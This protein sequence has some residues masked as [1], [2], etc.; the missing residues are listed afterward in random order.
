MAKFTFTNKD[1]LQLPDQA[2]VHDTLDA[3]GLHGKVVGL[4]V[5]IDGLTHGFPNDLDMLL[6]GPDGQHNL[7]FMSD[8]GGSVLSSG[9][10]FSFG[11]DGATHMTTLAEGTFLPTDNGSQEDASAWG[12]AIPVVNHPSSATFASAFGGIDGN[13]E[14]SL[15]S[16]DD[17]F[18]D[19]GL[20]HHWKVTVETD[21][22]SADLAGTD[23][24]DIIHV[25]SADGIGAYEINDWGTVTF[26]DVLTFAIDG[27][28]G[29]DLIISSGEGGGVIAGGTGRDTI[30]AGAGINY[31]SVT[32]ADDVG[33]VYDG[34]GGQDELSHY[35]YATLD[36]RDDTVVS[37][38]TI[39]SYGG[40]K[41]MVTAA[42]ANGLQFV[43]GYADI[44]HP[45]EFAVTMGA[46][47]NLNLGAVKVSIFAD[48]GDVIT[49]KGDG[50]AEGIVGS[51]VN[52]IIRAAGGDDWIQTN[53]GRDTVDGGKGN[54]SIDY[55]DRSLSVEVTLKGNKSANVKVDGVTEDRVKNVEN[56]TGGSAGDKLTGDKS[57]NSLSGNDGAD[58][59]KGG[60]GSDKLYG[61]FGADTLTGGGGADQFTFGST[62]DAFDHITDFSH[63]DDTIALSASDYAAFTSL[64]HIR[65]SAFHANAAGHDAHNAKQ[66]LIYDKAEGS[67]WYDADGNGQGAAVEVAVLDNKPGNLD[68]HDFMIA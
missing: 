55:S 9:W 43:T 32:D 64:G 66:H 60:L 3:Y 49:I 18:Q 63:V 34:G 5:T 41:I 67:L 53:L 48:A 65:A 44:T 29:N 26:E 8:T 56:V 27:L 46:T 10:S 35:G 59:L 40:G 1:Q 68:F 30:H 17:T 25:A 33:E 24:D 62:V 57:A 16:H 13:G 42:E 54:D 50:D 61:G 38:E 4:S 20:I 11:D 2:I 6:V 45:D 23:G 52:D 58:A 31:L 39:R 15:Y 7:E 36:L 28:G 22:F 21:N 51:K 37:I 12:L 19:G 14:W 47:T